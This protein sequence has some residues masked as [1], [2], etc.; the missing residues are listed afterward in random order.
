[1]YRK[2]CY[3]CKVVVVVGVLLIRPTDFAVVVSHYTIYFLANCK[4]I[5]ASFAVSP[6]L[7][8]VKSIL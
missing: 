3:T 7:A 5:N 4:Y 1:M 6:V 8:L 2:V